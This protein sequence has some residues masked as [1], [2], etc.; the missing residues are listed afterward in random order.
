ML[1]GT[2]REWTVVV[3]VKLPWIRVGSYVTRVHSVTQF[4][5]QL[6]VHMVWK[7]DGA[8]MKSQRKVGKGCMAHR[9]A[10]QSIL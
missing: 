6:F 3:G 8:K 1:R 7:C 5:P 4:F 10:E 2:K 9:M